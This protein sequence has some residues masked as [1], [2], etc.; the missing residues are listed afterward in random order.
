M[1]IYRVNFSTVESNFFFLL[2]VHSLYGS[3][4]MPCRKEHAATTAAMKQVRWRVWVSVIK[5]CYDG[6]HVCE[7]RW[8]W[9][10]LLPVWHLTGEHRMPGYVQAPSRVRKTEVRRELGQTP[11]VHQPGFFFFRKISLILLKIIF[12]L[13]NLLSPY[14][15]WPIRKPKNQFR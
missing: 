2:P 12:D 7:C 15:L 10:V 13:S 14:G 4:M 1:T 9:R 5:G 8:D 6:A 3:V 11:P